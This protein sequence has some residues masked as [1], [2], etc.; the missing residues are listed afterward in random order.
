[1]IRLILTLALTGSAALFAGCASGNQPAAGPCTYTVTGAAARPVQPPSQTEVATTGTATL[2]LETS[3]GKVTI[4]GD[5]AV[6]P[7]TWNALE[8]LAK[9]GYFNDT[10]CHR[11]ADSGLRMLQCGDPTGTGAGTPGY[12]YDDEIAPGTSYPAGTVAMA[13]AGPGTNGSQFF[14]VYG[15][16][17][18]PANYTVFGTVDPVSLRV[19]ETVAAQGHDD[20]YGDGT[21]R[22]REKFGI[23]TATAG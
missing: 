13:N 16:S 10:E 11:L 12:R 22:P 19:I 6:T 5:R 14:I 3:G 18:L 4:T 2:T 7:C 15:D 23:V 1:M 9:Q 20:S 21:G 17:A 8:S